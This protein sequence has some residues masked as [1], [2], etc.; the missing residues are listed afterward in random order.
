MN[1]NGKRRPVEDISGMGRRRI[2]ETSGRGEFK[3]DVFY[4][5]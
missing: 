1:V 4:I 2:K 3:Y 5:L